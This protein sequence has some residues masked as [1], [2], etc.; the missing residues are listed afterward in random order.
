LTDSLDH[1]FQIRHHLFIGEPQNPKTFRH[2]EGVAILIGFLSLLEVM[3]L[4]IELGDQFGREA[5][6][7]GDVVSDW[8]LPAKAE[9][10]DPTSLQITP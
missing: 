6:E 8:D 4:A 7:V 5:R 3:G 9:T 10:I 2:K 1:T